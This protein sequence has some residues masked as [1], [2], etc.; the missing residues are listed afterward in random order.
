MGAPLP[1]FPFH[2]DDF[3]NDEKLLHLS[4]E[5]RGIYIH[6]LCWQWREG[7]VPND[8]RMIARKLS[9]GTADARHVLTVCFA[10]AEGS[11]KRMVND[12]LARCYTEAIGKSEKARSAAKISAAVR[13]ANAQRM[14]NGPGA[15]VERFRSTVRST[16]T[17]SLDAAPETNGNGHT[18]VRAVPKPSRKVPS[19]SESREG[20]RRLR[21]PA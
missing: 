13:S 19:E 4:M 6:L 14:P 21:A 10:L 2:V 18:P 1:W 11:R 12:R 8:A 16:L 5:Q 9:V 20:F 15:D 3:E 17:K 7:T